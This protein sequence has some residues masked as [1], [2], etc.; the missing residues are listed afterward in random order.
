MMEAWNSLQNV[1]NEKIHCQKGGHPK[2]LHDEN[3]LNHNYSFDGFLSAFWIAIKN[4]IQYT[5][6]PQPIISEDIM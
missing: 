4:L 3:I 6:K 5:V 2:T 1:G